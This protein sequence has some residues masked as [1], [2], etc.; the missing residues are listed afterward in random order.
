M[1][2]VL[3]RLHDRAGVLLVVL[4]FVVLFALAKRVHRRNLRLLIRALARKDG[5]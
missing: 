1:N 3:E 5:L 4:G 2:A